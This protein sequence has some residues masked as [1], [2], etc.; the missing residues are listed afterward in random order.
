MARYMSLED[1]LP[2]LKARTFNNFKFLTEAEVKEAV[3]ALPGPSCITE[4]TASGS[5]EAGTSESGTT[6]AGKS[7]PLTP[8]EL[9]K[10]SKSAKTLNLT[11]N[12]KAAAV[13]LFLKDTFARCVKPTDLDSEDKNCLPESILEQL[14]NKDFMED[15]A[16]QA[17][18]TP[19][20]LRLQCVQY[21][22]DHYDD[23]S[24]ML[25]NYVTGTVKE[26]LYSMI[27]SKS[28]TDFPLLILARLVLEVSQ[29]TL[30]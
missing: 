30:H 12:R 2:L 18:Y 4:E 22:V 28:E 19:Q 10:L 5:G 8:S 25:L 7:R 17:I 24:P 9:G 27:S 11:D 26:Y 21:G 20:H 16:T 15:E 1:S 13:D 23:I 14:S 6:D 29:F 3:E